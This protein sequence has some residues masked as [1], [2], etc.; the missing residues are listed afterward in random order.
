MKKILFAGAFVLAIGAAVAT[1]ANASD[2]RFAV[3]QKSGSSCSTITC[4]GGSITCSNTFSDAGC[5]VPITVK[6]S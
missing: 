1:K 3:F 4:S 5:T 2:T 6:H